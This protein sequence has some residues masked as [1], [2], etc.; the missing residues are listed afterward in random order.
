MKTNKQFIDEV[1]QKYD[2]YTK[3][4][5]NKKQ[6]NAR[7]IVNMAAVV[8]VLI[9][10]IIVFSESEAPKRIEDSQVNQIARTDIELETVK[11]FENFYEIVKT[12]YASSVNRGFYVYEAITEDTAKSENTTDYSSS[13]TNTQVQNV[14]ESDVVK[15]DDRYIYY[16]SNK[17]IVIIDA[18][19]A[20]TS[21]KIAEINYEEFNPREI[22]VKNNKLIVIGNETESYSTTCKV[23]T[24]DIA[25]YDVAKLA[26]F[27]TGMILYD[28]SNIKEPKEIRRV[29]VQGSYIS[30]RM[31]E[32]NIYFVANQY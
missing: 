26:D 13:K 29:M 4:K 31:I 7:K 20:E 21:S 3:E 27:K 22:Y 14:D 19:N 2:E 12:K 23:D 10:S 18:Q 5:Q 1:Y 17:K 11:N 25:T 8:I 15:V 6:R 16:V 9:S 32:D 30:S 28:I 24:G